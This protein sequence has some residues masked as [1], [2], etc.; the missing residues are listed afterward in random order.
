[1]YRIAYRSSSQ[2][3]TYRSKIFTILIF[4]QCNISTIYITT[5]LKQLCIKMSTYQKYKKEDINFFDKGLPLL[6]QKAYKEFGYRPCWGGQLTF[7][8]KVPQRTQHKRP[9][10]KDTA[11]LN[12]YMKLSATVLS[13]QFFRNVFIHS[14]ATLSLL[15][16]VFFSPSLSR[17]CHL[18]NHTLILKIISDGNTPSIENLLRVVHRLNKTMVKQYIN[19]LE[20]LSPFSPICP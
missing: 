19:K 5:K 18:C 12:S 15:S 16:K 1:M 9:S 13:L 2:G 8:S 10:Q 7:N 14:S 6:L 4:S 20:F 17:I 3:V 11:L